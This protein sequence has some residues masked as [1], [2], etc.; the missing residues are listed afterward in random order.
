MKESLFRIQASASLLDQV[1]K[2]KKPIRVTRFRKAIAEVI[3]VAA[4]PQSGL[5]RLDER[6]DRD[7]GD[8]IS[9]QMTKTSGGVRD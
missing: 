1:Q 4:K 7:F 8:I 2:T 6:Q 9:R 5:V 3:P